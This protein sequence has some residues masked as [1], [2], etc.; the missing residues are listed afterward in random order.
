MEYLTV[1]ISSNGLQYS[2][3]PFKSFASKWSFS[4]KPP[5]PEHSQTNGADEAAVKTVKKK[6]WWKNAARQVRIGI[7]NLRKTP[8]ENVSTSPAQRLMD[9]RTKMLVPITFQL[10]QPLTAD[11]LDNERRQIVMKR[12]KVADIEKF[13]HRK[14]LKSLHVGDTIRVQPID[15]FNNKQWGGGIIAE[16]QLYI[17]MHWYI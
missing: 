5:S 4:H 2:S 16:K 7:L 1:V 14:T 9:R 12:S 17:Y 8:Q 10:L 11:K 6:T 13:I 15:T 3:T